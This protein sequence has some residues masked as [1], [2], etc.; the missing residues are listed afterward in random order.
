MQS[1]LVPAPTFGAPAAGILPG[2][3]RKTVGDLRKKLGNQ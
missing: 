1:I 3:A 2:P